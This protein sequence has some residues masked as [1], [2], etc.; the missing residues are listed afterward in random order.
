MKKVC[1]FF[2]LLLV[3]QL[4]SQAKF[5]IRDIDVVQNQHT[6]N[7]AWC[8]GLNAPVISE[9]NL[10]DDELLDLFLFDKYGNKVLT[11]I[12]QGEGNYPK[13]IYDPK[14]EQQFPQL[15]GW[16]VI[17]DFNHDNIPDIFT[18][19][20]NY[21]RCFRGKKV[22]G[23]LQFDT[24]KNLLTYQTGTF[25]NAI[26]TFVNDLPAFVDVNGDGDLDVMSF[27]I[28][29]GMTINYYENQSKELGY[30]ADSLLFLAYDFCWGHIAESGENNSL[31]F[32]AC[33]RDGNEQQQAPSVSRHQG[34]TL[35][36][37]DYEH[38]GDVD[39]LVGDV[40]YPTLTYAQNNGDNLSANITYIDTTFPKYD[41]PISLP[42]FPAAYT[43]DSDLWIAPF[44]Y[45]G[46]VGTSKDIRNI[47]H[48]K[49]IHD[50]QFDKYVYA[51]DTFFVNQIFDAGSD[52][53]AV[54]E[55][56]DNDGK[57]DIV[58]G[59]NGQYYNG[60]A[61]ISKLYYLK[62][63]SDEGAV[64]F[65]LKSEDWC[66]SSGWNMTG[67]Y[68]AF[69]DLDGDGLRDMLV[70]DNAGRLHFLKKNSGANPFPTITT[71][72]YFN[73]TVNGNAR[74]FIYDVN[75]DGLN[76]VLV[77]QRT[78]E[79]RYYWN[80]GTQSSSFFSPDSVN[81]FFGGV[82]VNDWRNSVLTGNASPFVKEENGV[83]YLYSGSERGMIFKY[84][85]NPDSLRGGAFVL[86]DSNYLQYNAGTRTTLDI[87]DINA[88]GGEEYLIGNSRGGLMM[89]SD[90][91]WNK[92][93]GINNVD[94]EK[95]SFFIYPNPA[96]T[97]VFIQSEISLNDTRYS[98]FDIAGKQ[99]LSGKLN[100]EK[101]ISTESLSNG[102]YILQLTNSRFSTAQ[103]F[104]VMK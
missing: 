54:F 46:S 57:L 3:Q 9:I 33:K 69:G 2:C 55:D 29:G 72:Q 11:F 8:G 50:T 19:N 14:Y 64:K 58:V 10:N 97:F 42:N 86:I 24:L 96:S 100:Q 35:F 67:I 47:Q 39:I 70:G 34:G 79:I 56:I 31:I 51:G 101:N 53:K 75:G 49:N 68:P 93:T 77:G 23:Q 48:Y 94:D 66:N 61:T 85:I 27:D 12:N 84:E 18:L 92:E 40:S 89:L 20:G 81:M 6:L 76:D 62:N 7:N 25:N 98:V 80:Y 74:P 15:K 90:I 73:I 44:N 78:G 82:R 88:D 95:R 43:I 103:K 99:Q 1:S 102:S 45:D 71:S 41:V 37:F 16:A 13:Y 21:I 91:N 83:L 17:R 63:T 65:E 87:A 104:V 60:S 26:W 22:A 32:A 52:S 36:A 30:E 38:D 59:E 4:F 28:N 5:V